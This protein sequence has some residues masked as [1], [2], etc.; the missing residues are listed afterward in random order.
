MAERSKGEVCVGGGWLRMCSSFWAVPIVSSSY[1]EPYR[2]MNTTHGVRLPF[3]IYTTFQAID[4]HMMRIWCPP[5]ILFPFL[6]Y[7]V[8]IRHAM[9]TCVVV[10]AK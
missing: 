1:F 10:A 3:G 2:E 5:D 4:P 8:P 6:T 7:C 9:S